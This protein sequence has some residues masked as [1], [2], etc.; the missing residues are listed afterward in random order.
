VIRRE[1]CRHD[2]DTGRRDEENQ[3]EPSAEEQLAADLVAQGQ[4][5]VVSLTGPDGLLKQ[6]TKTALET[7]LNQ[8]LT[9]HLGHQKHERVGNDAGNGRAGPAADLLFLRRQHGLP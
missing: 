1:R 5:Q 6:L 7:A 3:K 4:E 9:E 2:R 8:E